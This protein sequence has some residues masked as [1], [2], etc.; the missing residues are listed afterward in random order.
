MAE[1]DLLEFRVTRLEQRVDHMSETL[2]TKDDLR[3]LADTLREDMRSLRE[4]IRE[5]TRSLR[6]DMRS[7]RED[8]REDTRSLRED[9]RALHGRLN[10]LNIFILGATAVTVAS[11]VVTRLLT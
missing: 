10:S 9:N 11:V 4:D 3:V 5:D 1:Q 7:L 6:E 8:I 2:A